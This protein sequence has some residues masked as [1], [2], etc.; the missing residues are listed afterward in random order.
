MTISGAIHFDREGKAMFPV[1]V[2]EH[3]A[4]FDETGFE[5]EIV[6]RAYGQAGFFCRKR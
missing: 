2:S 6:W 4:L 1:R 5:A 3:L